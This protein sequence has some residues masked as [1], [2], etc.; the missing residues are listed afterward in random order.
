MQRSRLAADAGFYYGIS[1][2]FQTS[3][4]SVAASPPR[5]AC[6]FPEHALELYH[7]KE[8]NLPWILFTR[9]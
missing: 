3:L 1:G 6:M 8:K 5:V 9:G 4:V 2:Q 7:G